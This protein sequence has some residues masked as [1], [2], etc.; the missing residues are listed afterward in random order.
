MSVSGPA[1]PPL[2]ASLGAADTLLARVSSETIAIGDRRR[3]RQCRA[4][5]GDPGSFERS[6]RSP[7]GP[8]RSFDRARSPARRS[9]QCVMEED[10]GENSAYAKP[11]APSIFSQGAGWIF[12]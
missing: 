7:Q 2:G 10:V 6:G 12:G 3:R 8:G 9:G 5:V 4:E 11:N 1:L